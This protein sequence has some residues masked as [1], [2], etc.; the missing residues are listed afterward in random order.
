MNIPILVKVLSYVLL[1]G[2]VGGLLLQGLIYGFWFSLGLFVI[3]I[4]SDW[5]D[6]RLKRFFSYDFLF[7]RKD[8]GDFS[9]KDVRRDLGVV[10]RLGKDMNLLIFQ[11]E[12]QGLLSLEKDASLGEKADLIRVYNE[13]QKLL[14]VMNEMFWK[15]SGRV[16]MKVEKGKEIYFLHS[17]AFIYLYDAGSRLAVASNFVVYLLSLESETYKNLTRSLIFPSTQVFVRS[18]L[19]VLKKL[20]FSS[21]KV[22]KWKDKFVNDVKYSVGLSRFPYL[23][24]FKYYFSLV[25]LFKTQNLV[26]L[27]KS[28]LLFIDERKVRDGGVCMTD[29]DVEKVMKVLEPGDIVVQRRALSMSSWVI[30]GYWTHGAL[31]VGSREEL[32]D[33]FGIDAQSV[34]DKLDKLKLFDNKKYLFEAIKEGVSASDARVALKSDS[35]VVFKPKVG[36]FDRLRA[37]EYV[38]GQLEKE[39]DYGLDFLSENSFICSELVYKAYS[40]VESGENLLGFE[41]RMIGGLVFTFTPEDLYESCV[42]GLGER[43][44]VGICLKHDKKYEK[45]REVE[46]L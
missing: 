3:L 32:K 46:V 15:Y 18:G 40:D 2:V 22:R 24:S 11:L 17:A 19:Y 33:Y 23:A 30:P 12:E 10:L 34:L 27:L 41:P 13:L 38:L 25:K 28:F 7:D 5:N 6:W 20:K 37:V 31:Y 9:D 42:V 8:V 16:D 44:D 26:P 1:L 43:F 4:W 21:L 45:V 29:S 14:E 39:Y 35:I 36:E